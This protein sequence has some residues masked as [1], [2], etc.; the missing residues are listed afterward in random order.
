[1]ET[2]CTDLPRTWQCV[3]CMRDYETFDLATTPFN[4]PYWPSVDP[5]GRVQW[6]ELP[7]FCLECYFGKHHELTKPLTLAAWPDSSH[8]QTPDFLFTDRRG[9]I[10]EASL[11]YVLIEKGTYDEFEKELLA[12]RGLYSVTRQ[13]RE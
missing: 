13:A 4:Y 9:S 10:S 6:D 2:I 5:T 12:L 11:H 7:T 8:V 1:M 3:H